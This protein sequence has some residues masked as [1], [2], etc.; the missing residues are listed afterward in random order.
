[1]NRK[2][3]KVTSYIIDSSDRYSIDYL[4]YREQ[5]RIERLIR[6]LKTYNMI[7]YKEYAFEFMKEIKRGNFLGKYNEDED[8]YTYY[9][10]SD[11][12]FRKLYG[13][14]RLIYR[15]QGSKVILLDLQ[16]SKVFEEGAR[17]LLGTYH[18][19][20]VVDE[21]DKFKIDLLENIK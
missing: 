21:T 5:H 17:R 9:M 11:E 16:P 2:A 10:F 12:V 20:V 3:G 7:A 14:V 13:D 4:D 19:T 1:M 15:V 18:G 8:T 6:S